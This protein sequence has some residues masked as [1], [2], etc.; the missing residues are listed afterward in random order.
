[1]GLRAISARTLSPRLLLRPD[2]QCYRLHVL[3][4]A[5]FLGVTL[6]WVSIAIGQFRLVTR[7]RRSD[8]APGMTPPELHSSGDQVAEHRGLQG[9]FPRLVQ[10]HK[11]VVLFARLSCVGQGVRSLT[12]VVSQSRT[13][14]RAAAKK[15]WISVR[16][17]CIIPSGYARTNHD[18]C[19]AYAHIPG[20]ALDDSYGSPRFS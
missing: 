18:N 6:I 10:K 19:Y 2:S 17:V 1:M 20:K 5:L 9:N 3:N 13:L 14:S 8:R 11:D 4:R 12:I 16:S 15:I 7:P